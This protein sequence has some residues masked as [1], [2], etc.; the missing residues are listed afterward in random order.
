MCTDEPGPRVEETSHGE[1]SQALD[2]THCPL[3]S[4]AAA[5][6]QQWEALLAENDEGRGQTPSLK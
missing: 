6:A 5:G 4:Q 3:P 2:I 1:G